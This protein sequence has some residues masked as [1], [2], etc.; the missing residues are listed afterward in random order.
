MEAVS[1][2]CPGGHAVAGSRHR[3]QQRH[4]QFCRCHPPAPA[5]GYPSGRTGEGERRRERQVFSV[6]FLSRL[7]GFPL[8]KPRI[9]FSGG[10]RLSRRHPAG[11]RRSHTDH[12]RCGFR[13][14]IRQSAG[15]G[16]SF[17][18]SVHPTVF[19]LGYDPAGQRQWRY[20]DAGGLRRAGAAWPCFWR[21]SVST[22]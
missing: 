8:A 16:I 14:E 6:F 22:G 19:L 11:R 12:R 9:L 17:H 15:G 5:S 10:L 1:R 3:G 13:R 21:R 18:V 20:A 4:L 7:S 2:F